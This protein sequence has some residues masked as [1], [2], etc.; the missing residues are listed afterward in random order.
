M[1]KLNY[2]VL[3]TAGCPNFILKTAPERVMQCGE[4]NFLRAFVNYWFDIANETA[5]WN[6]KCVI[7]KP[8]NSASPTCQQLNDQQ[9]LYTLHL[10]GMERGKCVEESRVISSISRCLDPHTEDGFQ[11]MMRLAVSD[12][13]EYVVSNTTEAGIVYDLTCQLNDHP[14]SSFPGKLTQVLYARHQAGKPGLIIL[15]CELNDRNGDLLKDCVRKYAAQWN[16][17]P[18]FSK[19]IETDCLFC[20]TLV[21][22]I[23]PGGIRD[24][25]E[26]ARLNARDGYR[27]D[28]RVVSEVFGVWMIEAPQWLAERLPF[29]AAG[30]NCHV[31]P[32]VE[33][34]KKRKVRILNG[35]HTGLVLGAYLAGFDIV[36]DCMDNPILLSFM[37]RMLSREVIPTLPLDR[38]ELEAFVSAVKDR[39][40]NPFVN[41]K[42][43]SISLNSTAKWQTR[44]LPS[45]L[46][47]A[48]IHHQLPSCLAMTFAAYL[49]FYSSRI[50]ELTPEGLLCQRPNGD[51]YTCQDERWILELYFAH[52]EEDIPQLVHAIM[53]NQKLWGMDLTSI[54]DF[55][56]ATVANLRFLRENGALAAFGAC[57]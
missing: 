25:E 27:D 55:E 52:R 26:L 45:L 6:G 20:N 15:P 21:D 30:V 35:A 56:T 31:V 32:D 1:D 36:R 51:F 39:F 53:A 9:C 33:P 37:N 4:G 40:C 5:G 2:A 12:D 10:R 13:L 50:Q 24:L 34:Y 28:L 42:L 49:A 57:L 8:R 54:S 38:Q 11:E 19:Y 16:L 47:Y 29:H 17:G 18:S 3:E 46:E 41:H 48:S 23:V 14:C 44:I 7:V 22:R 43:L